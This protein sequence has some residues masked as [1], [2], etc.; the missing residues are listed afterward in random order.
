VV[1]TAREDGIWVR[2]YEEGGARLAER[3]LKLGET[4]EVPATARDPRLTTGRPDALAVTI[5]GR[6]VANLSDK[7]QTL[8]GLPISA[9]ALN[10]RV[11]TSATPVPGATPGTPGAVQSAPQAARPA[12][13]R[14][15]GAAAS[16]NPAAAEAAPAAQTEAAPAPAPAPAPAS[17]PAAPAGR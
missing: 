5:G 15:G 4:I 12:V 16:A 11:T 9:A 1:L 7:P 17:E 10:A 2:L 3:T 6:A 8:S 13:R 14:S